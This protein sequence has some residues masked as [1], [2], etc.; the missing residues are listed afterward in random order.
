MEQQTISKLT[1]MNLKGMS[2]TYHE[3]LATGQLTGQTIDQYLA[4]LADAEWE[5]RQNRK[6]SNLKRL[7]RFRQQAHPLN[8]DYTIETAMWTRMSYRD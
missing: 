2:Q 7:A 8:I 5:Y 6:V 3:D 4:K 1:A